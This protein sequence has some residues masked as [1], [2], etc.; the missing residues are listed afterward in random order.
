MNTASHEMFNVGQEVDWSE[1][2]AEVMKPSSFKTGPF[3]VA[4]VRDIKPD[5]SGQS[6]HPQSVTIANSIGDTREYSG[7]FLRVINPA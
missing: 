6:S 1:D 4:R 3:Q 2:M 5:N 7:K